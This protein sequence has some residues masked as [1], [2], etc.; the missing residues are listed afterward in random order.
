MSS[1]LNVIATLAF[2]VAGAGC[3]IIGGEESDDFAGHELVVTERSATTLRLQ[4]AAMPDAPQNAYTVDYFT[5]FDTCVFPTNHSDV[6]RVTGTTVQLTNLTPATGYNIHVHS[7]PARTSSTYVVLVNTLS[8]G[9]PS[10]AV[11]AADYRSCK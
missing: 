8:A 1:A 9:A 3:E 5:G 2:A 7:L 10:S 6:L 4:W 11:T